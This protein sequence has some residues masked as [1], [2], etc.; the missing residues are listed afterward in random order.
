MTYCLKKTPYFD[1]ADGIPVPTYTCDGD[2]W[3][4]LPINLSN[5]DQTYI[6]TKCSTEKKVETCKCKACED[7]AKAKEQAGKCACI[8]CIK[9][10]EEAKAQAA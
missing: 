9:K 7:A 4:N 8:T 6:F 3:V 2:E 10:A 1:S 5:K